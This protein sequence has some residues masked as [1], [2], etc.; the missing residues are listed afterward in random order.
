M[1]AGRPLRG[2]FVATPRS[3]L[4]FG[5]SRS[6]DFVLTVNQLKTALDEFLD[7][8]WH[9]P[10]LNNYDRPQWSALWKGKGELP[11]RLCPGCYALKSENGIEYIGSGIRRGKYSCSD[12]GIGGRASNYFLWNRGHDLKG[13][14]RTYRMIDGWVGIYTVGF[15]PEAGY[16]APALEHFLI[17]EL[18]PMQNKVKMSGGI[19]ANK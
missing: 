1:A 2:S 14:R 8:H 6:G 3:L 18:K 9:S 10:F 12:N 13:G 15:P 19:S 17:V 4:C 7:R 16:L 11:N 5:V